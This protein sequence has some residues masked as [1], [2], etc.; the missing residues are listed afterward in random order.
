VGLQASRQA[1][2]AHASAVVVLSPLAPRTRTAR[3]EALQ[4]ATYLWDNQWDIDELHEAASS[5]VS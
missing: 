1:V 5:S 2:S 3:P 4:V